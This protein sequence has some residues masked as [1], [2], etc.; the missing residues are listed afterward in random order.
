MLVQALQPSMAQERLPFSYRQAELVRWLCQVRLQH[1]YSY[2][3]LGLVQP[4]SMAQDQLVWLY[5]L[6]AAVLLRF[7]VTD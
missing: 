3:H 4:F 5:L 1:C 7:R 6:L 2:T